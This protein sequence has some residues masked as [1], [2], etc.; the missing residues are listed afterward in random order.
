MP[1][2]PKFLDRQMAVIYLAEVWGIHRTANTLKTYTCIGKGPE[3]TRVGGSSVYTPASLD[4]WVQSITLPPGKR[5]WNTINK[6][7]AVTAADPTRPRGDPGR[8][9]PAERP[10][11]QRKNRLHEEPAK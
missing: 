9:S 11:D 7:S 8:L 4:A 5:P 3:A 1:I 6:G 2:R 10:H